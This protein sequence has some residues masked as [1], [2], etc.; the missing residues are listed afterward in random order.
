MTVQNDK[1][2]NEWVNIE[3]TIRA[4]GTRGETTTRFYAREFVGRTTEEFVRQLLG[5][6]D[7]VVEP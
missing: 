7:L 6:H 5:A 3:V 2:L 1:A 4:Q